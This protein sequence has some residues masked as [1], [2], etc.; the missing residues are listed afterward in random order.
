MYDDRRHD[1]QLIQHGRDGLLAAL[2]LPFEGPILR[3]M[4]VNRHIG[5]ANSPSVV[6]PLQLAILVSI[7]IL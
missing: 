6:G 7:G 2:R 5:E 3:E 4:T 1:P